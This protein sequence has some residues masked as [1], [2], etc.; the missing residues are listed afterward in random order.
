MQTVKFP[1][2][3][4]IAGVAAALLPFIC[5]FSTSSS[6]T[7]NGVVVEESSTDFAAIVLGAVAIALGVVVLATLLGKTEESDRIKRLGAVGIMFVVG[8][9][10]LAVRGLGVI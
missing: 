6:R 4:E 2:S 7:V 1:A 8:A 9:F 10:Q 5:T 3:L